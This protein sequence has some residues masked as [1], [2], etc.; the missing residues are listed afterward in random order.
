MSESEKAA[1]LARQARFSNGDHFEVAA[2]HGRGAAVRVTTRMGAMLQMFYGAFGSAV[3]SAENLIRWNRMLRGVDALEAA[4]KESL[5]RSLANDT[6][7][8]VDVGFVIHGA[9]GLL[10]VDTLKGMLEASGAPPVLLASAYAGACAAGPDW[11]SKIG[12]DSWLRSVSGGV[13]VMQEAVTASRSELELIL[14]ARASGGAP[15]A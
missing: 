6:F 8:A 3:F 11:V 7:D 15:R 13:E 9:T 14:R 2:E 12:D 10:D 5:M 1:E 4:M